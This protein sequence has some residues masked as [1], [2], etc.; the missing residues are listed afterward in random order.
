MNLHVLK[1]YKYNY[2]KRFLIMNLIYE[3]NL[4]ENCF[5][6]YELSAVELSYSG[7]ITPFVCTRRSVGL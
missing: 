5:F 1:Q 3:I 4:Y 2:T 7:D 6:C